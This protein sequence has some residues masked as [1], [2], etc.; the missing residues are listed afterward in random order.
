[1]QGLAEKIDYTSLL[2][3]GFHKMSIDE[4]YDKCVSSFENNERR[5]EIYDHFIKFYELLSGVPIQFEIW[6][7]GSYTTE[8]EIP[9]DIDI[10]VFVSKSEMNNISDSDKRTVSYLF[11]DHDSTK[12]R[13]LT[14]AYI[15]PIE[16]VNM[17]SY[18]RGWFC[19]NRNEEPKGIIIVEAPK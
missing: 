16:D 11:S 2:E 7:D 12:A 17:R 6:I 8:K 4:M 9:G 5:Q 14:D 10:V 18:W 1:M 3:P 13:F 19:F 15:A